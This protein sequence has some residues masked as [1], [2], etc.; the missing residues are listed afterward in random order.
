MPGRV[1]L[2]DLPEAGPAVRRRWS[3]LN[4]ATVFAARPE[5]TGRALRGPSPFGC[6]GKSTITATRP[7]SRPIPLEQ[8]NNANSSHPLPSLYCRTARM[9]RPPPPAR[10]LRITGPCCAENARA[11]SSERN[12]PHAGRCRLGALVGRG[13]DLGPAGVASAGRVRGFIR[14]DI[15]ACGLPCP[16]AAP[17]FPTGAACHR[18]LRRS[19]PCAAPAPAPAPR[20]SVTAPG[21][22]KRFSRSGI[23]P[24]RTA[25]PRLARIFR[26]LVLICRLAGS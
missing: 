15:L 22:G 26:D 25:L 18:R 9:L 17:Q 5:E 2:P 20:A 24:L 12:C 4:A 6:P 11:S 7:K 23:D 16:G 19:A 21:R 10:D 14:T 1:R 8:P 3:S 13:R